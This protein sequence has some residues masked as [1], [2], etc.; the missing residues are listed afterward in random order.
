MKPAPTIQNLNTLFLLSLLF[1]AA[2]NLGYSR[3]YIVHITLASQELVLS[4]PHG[5]PG[6]HPL[7]DRTGAGEHHP[8]MRAIFQAHPATPVS[9]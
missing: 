3:C 8:E 2:L 4:E 7:S 6:A 1:D 5:L 9:G